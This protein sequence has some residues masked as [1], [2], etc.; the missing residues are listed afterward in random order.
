MDTSSFSA[1]GEQLEGFLAK[2]FTPPDGVQTVL[3]FFGAGGLAVAPGSFVGD[4]GNFNPARVNAWLNISLDVVSPVE[5]G[6]VGAAIRSATLLME[7]ISVFA[8]STAPAGSDAAH[9]LARIR[10]QVA[11]DLGG[12]T[13]IQ[14]APL[15]WYDPAEVPH[16]PKYSMSTGSQP[17]SA[18]PS[19]G[20][21]V[22]IHRPPIWAWRTV[23]TVQP[24][25]FIPVRPVRP[26]PMAV[27]GATMNKG[28][29]QSALSAKEVGSAE[30]TASVARVTV[31]P[32]PAL[33]RASNAL[34]FSQAT[35]AATDQASTQPVSTQSLSVDLTYNL[36]NLSRTPWWNDL[37]LSMG[38][39]YVPG[40][41]KGSWVGAS[42]PAQCY[43][44]PIA[45]ILTA[46]VQIKASWTQ[47]DRAA[48][49][50]S[51]HIGP[52]SLADSTFADTSGSGQAALVIPSMQA[53]GCIYHVLPALPPV[54]DPA[55]AA[56]LTS[57]SPVVVPVG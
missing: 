26:L 10:G 43:G 38:N 51:S 44:V 57:A 56:A 30:P 14:T 17:P 19:A 47:A 39:W 18:P 46:N 16:W 25:T 41:R 42:G 45:L 22:P 24:E 9:V 1:V 50:A 37:L 20:S 7:A 34:A 8:T 27:S 32:S 3:G 11:E 55:L 28:A 54:D 23:D 36:V 33:P 2:Q 31:Q 35:K 52:W 49:A 15:N 53:I 29:I 12:A 5:S 4:D 21:P 6:V 13:V 40:Q 48:A